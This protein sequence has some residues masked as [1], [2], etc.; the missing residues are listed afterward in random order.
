MSS[1]K[2]LAGLLLSFSLSYAGGALAGQDEFCEGYYRGYLE[3]YKRE[4]GSIFQPSVPLCP[5]MPRKTGR[6]PRDDNEHGYEFGY[7]QGREAARR[8][9]N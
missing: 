4:G 8:R 2:L 5:L 3:G 9:F 1:S 7:D 6:D